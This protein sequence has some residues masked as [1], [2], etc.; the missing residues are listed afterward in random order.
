MAPKIMKRAS[1]VLK[2]RVGRPCGLVVRG[3]YT[4][5]TSPCIQWIFHGDLFVEP[6]VG[7]TPRN[8]GHVQSI[9]NSYHECGSVPQTL[10]P[11]DSFGIA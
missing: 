5:V 7:C 4:N 8:S 11:W 10:I 3:H 6:L 9:S 1:G 2:R